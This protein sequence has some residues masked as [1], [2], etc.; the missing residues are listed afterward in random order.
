M[1]G[2]GGGVYRLGRGSVGQDEISQSVVLTA[3][4]FYIF[5]VTIT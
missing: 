2:G 5:I 4:D 1:G 3:V